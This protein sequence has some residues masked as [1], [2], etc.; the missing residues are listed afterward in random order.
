MYIC[1][2]SHL[3]LTVVLG[4]LLVSHACVA[5]YA[6]GVAKKKRTGGMQRQREL[7]A[8]DTL[9]D[10]ADR[11]NSSDLSFTIKLRDDAAA[12]RRKH[13]RGNRRKH[14]ASERPDASQSPSG[15]TH[16]HSCGY[17]EDASPGDVLFA[18]ETFTLLVSCPG[19]ETIKARMHR[20][21]EY[22][23]DCTPALI[24]CR[25]CMCLKPRV[26]VISEYCV[27]CYDEI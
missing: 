7:L 20:E 17:A 18:P 26:C 25:V 27:E 10:F 14:V 19:C 23:G 3:L 22:C 11:H 2:A 9:A 15:T 21:S 8:L 12:I 4:V 1:T 24:S 6:C 16:D 5:I 13:A